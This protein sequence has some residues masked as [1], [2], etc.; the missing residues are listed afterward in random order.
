[1]APVTVPRSSLHIVMA[2]VPKNSA[3]FVGFKSICA[4]DDC[5]SIEPE[6]A[7]KVFTTEAGT[8][9]Y[10]GAQ[11][12]DLHSIKGWVRNLGGCT[13]EATM[14]DITLASLSLLIALLAMMAAAEVGQRRRSRH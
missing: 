5:T 8:K 7:V 6:A 13:Q 9:R 10:D 2:C 3:S 11:G 14:T 1:M 12:R 4:M